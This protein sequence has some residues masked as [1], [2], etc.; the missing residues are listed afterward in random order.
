MWQVFARY[1]M[2]PRA[3][4]PDNGLRRVTADKGT[5][6]RI[7]HVT[8]FR[9]AAAPALTNGVPARVADASAWISADPATATLTLNRVEPPQL[10]AVTSA[11]SGLPAI[12]FLIPTDQG[13]AAYDA[14]SGS[15]AVCTPAPDGSSLSVG[16]PLT[17]PRPFPQ[18]VSV[19]GLFAGYDDASGQLGVFDLSS[20]APVELGGSNDLGTGQ[21]AMPFPIGGDPGMLLFERATGTVGQVV[22][23]PQSGFSGFGEGGKGLVDA[24]LVVPLLLEAGQFLL[25][26]RDSDG[27]MQIDAV[28]PAGELET[29]MADVWTRGWTSVVPIALL[30]QPAVLSYKSGSGTVEVGFIAV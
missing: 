14:G 28:D 24:T 21:I 20:G 29:V 23:D 30:G 26:Y 5:T 19:G 2:G 13:C 27:A 10:T 1:G 4:S 3:T 25:T 22:I 15:L 9:T 16:A 11:G 8:A 6:G 18:L 12:S 17:L 7:A